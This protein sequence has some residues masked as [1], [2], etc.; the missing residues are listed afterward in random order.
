[1]AKHM[2]IINDQIFLEILNFLDAADYY[3]KKITTV[4]AIFNSIVIQCS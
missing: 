4:I 2:L 3:G 1:M